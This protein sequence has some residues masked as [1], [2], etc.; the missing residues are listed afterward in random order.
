MTFGEGCERRD[1]SDA[2]AVAVDDDAE[3]AEL[4][5]RA[6]EAFGLHAEAPAVALKE[7]RVNNAIRSAIEGSLGSLT[8]ANPDPQK[9]IAA[10]E[11][12]FKTRDAKALP[13]LQA[14]LAKESDPHVAEALR[15]AQAAIVAVSDNAP[16]QDRLAAIDILKARGDQDAQS[17]IDQMMQK[18]TD[19]VVKS[20][21][22]S[23]LSTIHARL[24]IW[25]AAQD[26]WYGLSASSVRHV[27]DAHHAEG[28]GEADRRERTARW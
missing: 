15:L 5:E 24:A 25:G 10:A 13:A 8:L 1:V 17:L 28:D 12:V 2:D 14:Q 18:T 11:D 21:G 4:A 19:P 7:V 23:A 6:R 9:R 16:S 27:D 26:L 22:E 3:F 20:A